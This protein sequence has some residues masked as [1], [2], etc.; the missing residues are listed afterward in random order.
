MNNSVISLQE[1][2]QQVQSWG[3]NNILAWRFNKATLKVLIEKYPE[4]V[5]F[6]L[7]NKNGMEKPDL[8]AV[9]VRQDEKGIYRDQTNMLFMSELTYGSLDD[10][11]SPDPNSPLF[12]GKIDEQ[13]L[14]KLNEN[15]RR[16]IRNSVMATSNWRDN[17]TRRTPT[18]TDLNFIKAW[19]FKDRPGDPEATGWREWILSVEASK[20]EYVRFYLAT[21]LVNGQ[22]E[23]TL[24]AVKVDDQGNDMLL[25]REVPQIKEDGIESETG[26]CKYDIHA[27]FFK[28]T[29]IDMVLNF[30]DPCPSICDDQSPLI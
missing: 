5:R 8:V 11:V 9:G 29:G 7:A 20:F 14:E 30:A 26:D 17:L 15:E 23:D 27:L 3:K 22:T 4:G 2:K 28:N 18:N 25:V 12:N 21:K 1:A 24:L 19:L 16:L 10:E 6:Y 13:A